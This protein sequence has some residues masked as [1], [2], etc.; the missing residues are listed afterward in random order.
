MKNLLVISFCCL[1]F[2]CKAITVPVIK[3]VDS[4]NI[5]SIENSRVNFSLILTVENSNSL[6]ISGKDL[7]F[8]ITHQNILIGLGTCSSDF[9]LKANSVSQIPMDVV[10]NI[11]SIPENLRLNLFEMDSILLDIQ[12]SFQGK[13]GMKHHKSSEFLLP[14]LMIQ[15][16]IIESYFSSSSIKLDELTLISGTSTQSIFKGEISFLNSLPERI[17]MYHSEI[18]IYSDNKK[19]SMIGI[20]E[21]S[22]TIAINSNENVVIPCKISID[23]IKAIGIGLGKMMSGNLDYYANGPAQIQMIEKQFKIPISIHFTYNPMTGKITILN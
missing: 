2:S 20:L 4:L 16:A 14:I 21:I 10:L 5:E 6:S 19:S 22:D 15:D 11:D 9:E 23:N 8:E 18:S 12:M 17:E 1:L 3:K 7:L 13:L